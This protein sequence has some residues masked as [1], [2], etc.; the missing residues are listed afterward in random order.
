MKHLEKEF[1]KGGSDMKT[2]YLNSN[3]LG[4]F[5]KKANSNV[6]ALGFFDGVHKG[7]LEVINTAKTKAM[8]KGIPLTVMSFFPHPKN[9]LSNG[10]KQVNYLMPLSEKERVLRELGVETFYIVEFDLE[11]SKLSPQQFALQYLNGLGVIHVVAGFDYTYG[12]RGEGNLDR[13]NSDSGGVLEVTKVSKVEC[14]GEKIS[15]TCI[16]EKVLSGQVDK[17]PALL[18]RPYQIE[19]DW[20]GTLLQVKPYYTLPAPGKYSVTIVDDKY[21]LPGEVI[22]TEKKELLLLKPFSVGH[23][24]MGDSLTITW[25]QRIVKELSSSLNDH[26]IFLMA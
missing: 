1:V 4:D 11:F 14:H 6:M 7:H 26:R 10:Q 8:E 3:N 12:S 16:R 2:I 19:C 5:Q 23:T 13:L 17:I 24:K 21:S 20:N 25:H 15:S 9:V 18:D 22:V